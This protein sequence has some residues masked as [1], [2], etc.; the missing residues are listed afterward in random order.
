MITSTGS[1]QVKRVIQLEKKS[2]ARRESGLFVVEGVK[3]VTEAPAERL[4][5][6]YMSERFASDNMDFI[7]RLGI[8]KNT[9]EIVSDT[10][11]DHMSDTQTPQGVMALV[12]MR[13]YS[14]DDILVQP[15]DSAGGRRP[16][17]IGVENLQDPGNLGTIVRM[18]EGAGVT[19]I[20][21]SSNAVDIYNPKTIRSTMGSIYRVPFVY[22]NDFTGA[23]K[24]MKAA[25]VNVYAAHLDGEFEY[26]EPDY[27]KAS[28]FLIGNEGNGLT[29][30]ACDAASQLVKI[31]MEGN[32]ESL[33]AA[34]ACTVLTYE[35]MRQ[36]RYSN[37]LK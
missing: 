13:E 37:L 23:V 6:L 18:A 3:M 10:V 31:P 14:L 20:V 21:I 16:L 24:S 30:K 34:V 33:N 17:I 12:R 15:S 19:G 36:R 35:A 2:K 4:E 27:T 1:A 8:N 22:V 5:R 32:V 25:G 28:A 29:Q 7:Q 9:A 26:T 11:F